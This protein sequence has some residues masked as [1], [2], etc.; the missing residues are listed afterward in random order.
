MRVD[1]NTRR[2]VAIF[3]VALFIGAGVP[4]FS[5]SV[6]SARELSN[7][8]DNFAGGMARSLPFN[9]TMGLNWSDAYIGRFFPSFP[10]RFGVGVVGGATTM[11]LA[12]I[13]GLLSAF[14]FDGELPSLMGRFPI[15]GVMVEARLGGFF[16]PFDLGFKIGSIP[17]VPGSIEVDYFIVGGDFRYALLHGR[18]IL[19]TISVGVGFTHLRGGISTTL[20]QGFN[21]DL[22]SGRTVIVSDPRVGIDWSTSVLDFKVQASRS[23]LVVTPYV[24]LGLSHGWSRV[25][26]GVDAG[27]ATTGINEGQ[28]REILGQYGIDLGTGGFS[29]E[30]GINGWSVRAFGGISLNLMVLRLDF[31]ALYNFR[32]GNLGATIGAR[33]QI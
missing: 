26:Y 20:D 5:Q 10:P 3:F 15:P 19:P 22:G 12:P 4:A 1:S 21:V 27:I 17:N 18:R 25:S 2:K 14:G 28:A 9:A 31:T 33:I 24:G 23:L 11:D 7:A 8:M 6:T 32:D 29:S 13:D 30:V 16:L